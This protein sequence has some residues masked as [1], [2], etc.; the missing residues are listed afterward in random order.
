MAEF[1]AMRFW[2]D[3]YLGDT[4]HLT[5]IEHGAY[6]LLLITAWRSK[7]H[8]LPD[9]DVL[10]RQYCKLDRKQWKRIRPR[11]EP[12]FE[13]NSGYWFHLK[14][15]DEIDAIR[16]QREQRSHAAIRGAIK[17]K[18]RSRTWNPNTKAVQTASIQRPDSTDSKLLETQETMSADA[19][20][21]PSGCLAT[22]TI[23]TKEEAAEKKNGSIATEEL[24][25]SLQ[26]RGWLPGKAN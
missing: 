10:L 11:L 3:A 24:I 7:A 4:T 26:E 25:R 6:I 2:T 18:H 13:I 16:R 15:L 22:I 8:C 23:Q 20:R 14:I 9:D 12:F 17:R 1:P 19:Q 5:T 21:M